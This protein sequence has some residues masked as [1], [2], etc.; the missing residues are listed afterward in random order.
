MLAGGHASNPYHIYYSFFI[1]V[2]NNLDVKTGFQIASIEI[3]EIETF[4]TEM[5]SGKD[6]SEEWPFT[7]CRT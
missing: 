4:S 1:I 7:P 2:Q 5:G 3:F 6:F